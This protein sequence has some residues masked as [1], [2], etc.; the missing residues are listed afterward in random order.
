MSVLEG[1]LLQIDLNERRS[2]FL[3]SMQR[4]NN[5]ERKKVLEEID[6]A[7]AAY[8]GSSDG[9]RSPKNYQPAKEHR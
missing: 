7:L 5:V 4:D 9:I 2:L 6:V 1:R 8:G 3:G